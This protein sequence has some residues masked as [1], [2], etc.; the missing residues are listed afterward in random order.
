[1][2]VVRGGRRAVSFF[3]VGGKLRRVREDEKCQ[4]Q[5]FL[6]IVSP[7]CRLPNLI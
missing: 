7:L 1:M 3:I 6:D 4:E 5:R 2:P